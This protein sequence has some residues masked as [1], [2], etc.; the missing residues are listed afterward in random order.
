MIQVEGC[1]PFEGIIRVTDE[2]KM[3]IEMNGEQ[4]SAILPDQIDESCVLVWQADGV[5]RSCPIDV[6]RQTIRSL[7]VYIT[8]EERRKA[9]RLRV[10]PDLHFERVPPERVK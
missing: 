6:A 3:I 9:P 1:K 4:E 2:K 8:L 7:I 10:D 5:Q